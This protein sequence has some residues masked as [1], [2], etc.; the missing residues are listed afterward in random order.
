MILLAHPSGNAN[1]R[2]VLH[3][4]Q[5]VGQLAKFITALGW[6]SHGPLLRALPP[7]LRRTLARRSY[8]LPNEKIEMQSSREIVRL[9]AGAAKVGP[10][11]RHEQGWASID[12]VWTRIDGAAAAWLCAQH[13]KDKVRGVYAYEDCA[14][15]VFEN[16]RVLGVRLSLIH[17]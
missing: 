10:L 6:S 16:A 2:A 17:I 13:A 11:L 8:D 12:R 7:T 15:R 9:L 3:A 1:V 14:L 5:E 4:L